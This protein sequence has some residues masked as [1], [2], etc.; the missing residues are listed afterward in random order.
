MWE[1]EKL[2]ECNERGERDEQSYNSRH[3]NSLG[4]LMSLRRRSRFR[5]SS[6]AHMKSG[7]SIE[8]AHTRLFLASQPPEYWGLGRGGVGSIV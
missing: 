7:Q 8:I 3:G 4:Y 6:N 2:C 5:M 1:G